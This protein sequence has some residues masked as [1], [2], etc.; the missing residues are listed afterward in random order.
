MVALNTE[1]CPGPASPA[2]ESQACVPPLPT[3]TALPVGSE[4][5]I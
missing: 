5:M 4:G 3:Q 2:L 1:R